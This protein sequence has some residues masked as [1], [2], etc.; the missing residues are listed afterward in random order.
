MKVLLIEDNEKLNVLIAEFLRRNHYEVIQAYSLSEGKQHLSS[1]QLVLLD[2]MLP[3]GEGFAL[4]QEIRKNSSL[5]II[6]LTARDTK[7]DIIY[8]LSL[9]ADDYLVKPFE[10]EELLLRMKKILNAPK[11]EVVSLSMRDSVFQ[12]LSSFLDLSQFTSSEI[13]ILKLLSGKLDQPVSRE[14]IADLFLTHVS[15]RS[16]DVQIN[17]LRKKLQDYPNIS[18]R[19]VRHQG[20]ALALGFG[21]EKSNNIRSSKEKG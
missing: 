8:G 6:I 3:D 15:D 18:I 5:S 17:R 12:E 2:I 11:P 7:E 21:G 16:V 20:Y 4:V 13:K 19:T 9:G 1:V 14:T 10:P